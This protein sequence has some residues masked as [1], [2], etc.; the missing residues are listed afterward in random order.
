M[1]DGVGLGEGW[2]GASSGGRRWWA[3]SARWKQWAASARWKQWA[4]AVGRRVRWRLGS[5]G[6][7]VRG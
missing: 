3:A 7:H 6:E 2:G 4:A 1:D 5:K